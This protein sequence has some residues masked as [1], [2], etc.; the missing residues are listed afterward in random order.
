MM[1]VRL[2]KGA[3]MRQDETAVRRLREEHRRRKTLTRIEYAVTLV[4]TS[5]GRILCLAFLAV[6]LYFAVTGGVDLVRRLTHLPPAPSQS[7]TE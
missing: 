2:L 5:A 1:V 7:L 6:V 3:A 4:G